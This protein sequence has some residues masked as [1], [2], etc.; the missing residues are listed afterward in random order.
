MDAQTPQS[1]R[2]PLHTTVGF[3]LRISVCPPI[4]PDTSWEYPL[5]VSGYYHLDS[6]PFALFFATNS[7][8]LTL[9]FRASLPSGVGLSM[10]IPSIFFANFL[11]RSRCTSLLYFSTLLVAAF[12]ELVAF[13]APAAVRP[14]ASRNPYVTPPPPLLDVSIQFPLP[15]LS[16]VALMRQT[17][18]MITVA[19]KVDKLV[20]VS[21]RPPHVRALVII[22]PGTAVAVFHSARIYKGHVL[23]TRLYW[24]TK[25]NMTLS[26]PH[27]PSILLESKVGRVGSC[28]MEKKGNRPPS[29]LAMLSRLQN[30]SSSSCVVD[31]GRWVD[32]WSKTRP[33]RW[34]GV[35][36]SVNRHLYTS[37][38]STDGVRRFDE[39]A[40]GE[41]AQVY[42]IVRGQSRSAAQAPRAPP[43]PPLPLHRADPD[44]PLLP[45]VHLLT[46]V[47]PSTNSSSCPWTIVESE[48]YRLCAQSG[49][50][51]E[52]V[53]T[54]GIPDAAKCAKFTAWT[55]CSN[56]ASGGS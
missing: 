29:T 50:K 55:S 18:S 20:W 2:P 12:F 35:L 24:V 48:S 44:P 34:C 56:A 3:V 19:V 45:Q 49:E 54:I 7:I 33:G 1:I 17:T 42:G 38:I 13:D 47:L 27:F 37:R 41:G 52:Y 26:T 21:V 53:V 23:A 30:G 22:A 16:T 43:P 39:H 6:R 14:Y 8:P 46:L 11:R 25:S 10:D 15:L 4:I 5:K 40:E 31:E 36:V 32:S 51:Y 28:V 9:N